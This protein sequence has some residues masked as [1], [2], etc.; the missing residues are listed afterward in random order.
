MVAMAI[1]GP[2]I[3]GPVNGQG[4][5][6]LSVSDVLEIRGGRS[7]RLER[8]LCL[9]Y[10]PTGQ[11]NVCSAS[12]LPNPQIFIDEMLKVQ[13]G[14]MLYVP[15]IEVTARSQIMDENERKLHLILGNMG[16]LMDNCFRESNT[17]PIVPN[18]YVSNTHISVDGQVPGTAPGTPWP[19]ST[20]LN[21]HWKHL[22]ET[23]IDLK[24]FF[25]ENLTD[26][27]RV[28]EYLK[29]QTETIGEEITSEE[30]CHEIKNLKN[31]SAMGE[32]G[33]HNLMLKNL[34]ANFLLLISK[35]A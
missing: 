30:V 16:L 22:T 7:T 18:P 9:A 25:K 24:I 4:L 3:S 2:A 23:A 20:Y 10:L 17:S 35:L 13:E 15:S 26:I 21:D 28:D 5:F 33:I 31:A 8:A 29:D 6:M 27:K 12:S 19:L 14:K 11:G 32:S 1:S 34:P